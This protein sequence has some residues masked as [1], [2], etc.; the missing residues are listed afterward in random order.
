[1]TPLRQRMID[2]M[3][4]RNLSPHTIDAYVHAVA[5][6]A[7]HY[8][9]SPDELDAEQARAYLLHLVQDRHASWS[10]YNQARC[11]L[12]FLYRFV[13][14]QDGERFERA[15]PAPARPSACRRSCRPTSCGGC[16]TSWP[17]IPSTGPCCSRSTA[18]GCASPRR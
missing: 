10:R 13:L 7:K 3:R 1:M 4:L 18:R 15:S 8:R 16:S 17:A 6:F 12:Q 11:A 5:Q 9:R 2:D 14:K